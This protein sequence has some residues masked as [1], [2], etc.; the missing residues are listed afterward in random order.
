MGKC[1]FLNSGGSIKA[2]AANEIVLNAEKSGQLKPGGTICEASG[3][4]T[5]IALAMLAAE[6]NYKLIVTVVEGIAQEKI[7]N[8][9]K[10]G[11]K[12]IVCPAV[13]ISDSRYY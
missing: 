3:G 7:D 9:E 6:K 13:G 12:V 11:G 4:N 1:E 2:R 5:A 8:I 10:Y